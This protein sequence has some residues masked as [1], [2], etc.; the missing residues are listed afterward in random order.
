[1][2]HDQHGAKYYIIKNSWGE[3]GTKDGYLYMSE[4]YVRL[5]TVAIILHKDGVGGSAAAADTADAATD[6]PAADAGS[7]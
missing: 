3:T 4:A 2:A 5:K 7:R 1:M 6:A